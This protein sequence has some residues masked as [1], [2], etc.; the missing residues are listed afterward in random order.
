[1]YPNNY[2]N[3]MKYVSG[4]SYLIPYIR[5]Y[6]NKKLSLNLGYQRMDGNIYMPK[7]CKLDRLYPLKSA[8]VQAVRGDKIQ[9]V[10]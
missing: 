2:T 10:F 8:I 7:N 9:D 3:L 5:D 6:T 4:K 1:M